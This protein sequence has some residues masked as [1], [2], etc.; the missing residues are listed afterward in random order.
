M[1]LDSPNTPLL[2]PD[3]I[4]NSSDI[5]VDGTARSTKYRH[6]GKARAEY[7]RLRSEKLSVHRQRQFVFGAI[8][9]TMFQGYFEV[10]PL[11]SDYNLAV[12]LPSNKVST[13]KVR[14]VSPEDGYDKRNVLRSVLELGR[15]LSGPGNARG[16]R[17]GD[18]GSMHAIGLKSASSKELYK[19][20]EHTINKAASASTVMREWLEDNLR[21][22]LREVIRNDSEMKVNYPSSMPR[23]P[24]SRMMVSVNLA[25]SPHYD[26]GDTSRSI[27]IWVEEKPG[28]SENWYFVLPNVSHQGSQ[29]LVIKLAHGVVI[30]W[31]GREI[32]HCTS[33]TTQGDKNKTYGCMWGS[34]RKK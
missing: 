11:C 20:N 26:K 4:E 8:Y 9:E 10:N 1:D 6:V 28:Q 15:C 16:V 2:P 32:Y 14:L 27:G 22:D 30:T 33:K 21:D 18:K 3:L 31:D 29:G 5:S 34:S 12:T 7:N 13:L 19:T 17:V 23:G 25:N 24:G